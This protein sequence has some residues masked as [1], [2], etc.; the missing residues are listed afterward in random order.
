MIFFLICLVDIQASCAKCD[1]TIFR[2]RGR[3]IIECPDCKHLCA[4]I[5][6]N[7]CNTPFVF[8]V[9]LS[10]FPCVQCRMFYCFYF[11]FNCI[12]SILFF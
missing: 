5:T 4:P 11:N 10:E 7:K 9:G 1:K 3:K 2:E 12:D 8:P 6:C